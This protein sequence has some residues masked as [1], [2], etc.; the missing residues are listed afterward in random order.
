MGPLA[1]GQAGAIGDS[2]ERVR[3]FYGLPL[4]EEER[5]RLDR[6][7]TACAASAPA[8]RWAPAANLHL[9]IRFLGHVDEAAADGITDR[10]VDMEL[11]AFDL[12][13]GDLGTF[14]RGRL[15]RVVWMGLAQ[16][17][18]PVRELAATVEAECVRAGLE[19][20]T[21]RF[22]AHLTLARARARDGALLPELAAPPQLPGWRAQE[23]V[24]FRSHLGRSGPVYEAL[25]TLRLS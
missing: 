1:L 19:P 14:K 15:V 6:Y 5:A 10:L 22:N 11:R 18:E 21:R 17:E 16:G 24:L 9:T 23:L 8:F 20:E 13:L 3:A 2:A 12:R 25:R 4:P 7:V